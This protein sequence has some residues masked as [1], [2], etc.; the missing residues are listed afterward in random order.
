MTIEEIRKNAPTDATHYFQNS[1]GL[2]YF[3]KSHTTWWAWIEGEK[4]WSQQKIKIEW[5]LKFKPLS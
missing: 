3:R 2:V 1:F 5:R 4:Y